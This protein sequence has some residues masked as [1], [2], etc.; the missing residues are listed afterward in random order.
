MPSLPLPPFGAY[1]DSMI[2]KRVT[3]YYAECGRAFWKKDA[4]IRHE[5]FCKCWTNPKHRT[6]KSCKHMRVV[7]DNNG[8]QDEPHLLD[9]WRMI[10]CKNPV[11]DYDKHFTPA[12]EKAADLCINC[13]VWEGKNG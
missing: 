13:P 11:F 7:K 8:M 9:T 3:R 5:E 10:E 12:H 2:A 1:E 6:C 4:C